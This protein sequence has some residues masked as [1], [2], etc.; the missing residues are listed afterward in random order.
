MHV[1]WPAVV[2]PGT[3][4]LP[5]QI[6]IVKANLEAAELFIHVDFAKRR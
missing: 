1:Y 3:N 4:F 6:P 2:P 5:V